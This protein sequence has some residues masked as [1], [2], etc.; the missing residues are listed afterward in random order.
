MPDEADQNLLWRFD[1][2]LR[3]W[4]KGLIE[5]STLYFIY[6]SVRDRTEGTSMAEN[7]QEEIV[8]PSDILKEAVEKADY[9]EKRIEIR[10]A[11]DVEDVLL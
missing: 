5:S 4:S 8:W 6:C 2:S 3:D 1:S 10:L 7:N 9:E 11:P